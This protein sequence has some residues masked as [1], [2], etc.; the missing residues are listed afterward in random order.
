[1]ISDAPNILACHFHFMC[2]TTEQ[3]QSATEPMISHVDVGA[4]EDIT[5][6]DLAK[7]IID[8]VEFQREI[9][10]DIDYPRSTIFARITWKK[11]LGNAV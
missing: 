7:L 10:F 11:N 9:T 8:I 1:M 5:I 4:G 6:R 3:Y 2:P